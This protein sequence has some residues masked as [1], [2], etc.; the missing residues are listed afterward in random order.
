[1]KAFFDCV[2]CL[3]RQTLDA[4]RMAS[5]DV[6]LHERVLKRVLQRSSEWSFE[7]SPPEMSREIHRI[8]REETGDPDPYREAKSRHNRFALALLPELR[9]RVLDSRDGFEA[10]VRL[11]IAG[12]IMDFAGPGGLGEKLVLETIEDALTRP[13]AVDH[14]GHLR[15]AIEKANSILYLG[16]NAGE[17]ALDRLLLEQMPRGKV[18]FAVR[19]SPVIN[20]ATV[21]DAEAVGLRGL[22]SVVDNG[23]D[24]PGTILE[25]CS[26]DFRTRFWCADLVISKGQG[27]YETLSCENRE[28]FH[29]LKAKCPEIARDI[30]CEVGDI[31]VLQRAPSPSSLRGRARSSRRGDVAIICA[32][33]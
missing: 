12:N 21:E 13:L 32:L 24:A 17:I 31:L 5:E 33:A 20:D 14:I 10:A 19:G 29:L 30:G 2:P 4:C 26:E 16:D 7:R 23:A 18:T 9:K 1:M 11:A 22:V 28:V 15:R 8:I 25:A 3:L 27:N 6:S